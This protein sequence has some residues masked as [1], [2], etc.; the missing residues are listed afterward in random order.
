MAGLAINAEATRPCSWV[1]PMAAGEELGN[2]EAFECAAA[3]A[4]S[5]M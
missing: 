2:W 3:T 5:S 1:Y 4:E